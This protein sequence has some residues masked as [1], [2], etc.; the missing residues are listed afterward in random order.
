MDT[1]IVGLAGKK[2]SG[3][4]TAF[5]YLSNMNGINPVRCAFADILK[6]IC[7]LL[8]GFTNEQA[9]GDKKDEL[10]Q[11]EWKNI[12][13]FIK[14]RYPNSSK[15]KYLTFRE[16]YQIVGTDIFRL[17]FDNDIWVKALF[18]KIFIPGISFNSIVITDVRFVNELNAIKEHNGGVFNIIRPNL[19]EDD[20][21]A[22]ETSL[23]GYSNW[24][25]VIVNDSTIDDFGKK[26]QAVVGKWM[27]E[28]KIKLLGG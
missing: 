10:S 22:S 8:F 9:F 18:R 15:N 24:D 3:K 1:I 11:V 19:H 21:H 16:I 23:D 20:Q 7:I 25:G 5:E 14:D 17:M 2:H 26:V 6:N 4:D 13:Q 27:L 12:P 28:K